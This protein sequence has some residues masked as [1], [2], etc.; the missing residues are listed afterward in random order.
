MLR[1][2]TLVGLIVITALVLGIYLVDALQVNVMALQL[3]QVGASYSPFRFEWIA[4]S[5]TVRTDR[6]VSER[7]TAIALASRMPEKG[8]SILVLANLYLL[9][10]EPWRTESLLESNDTEVARYLKAIACYWRSGSNCAIRDLDV[11]RALNR[12]GLNLWRVGET[13]EGF[14]RLLLAEQLDRSPTPD[15]AL[16]YAI[17]SAGANTIQHDSTAAIYWAQLRI[18]VQPSEPGGYLD[19]AALYLS[20]D[21]ADA[22]R[23]TLRMVEQMNV[24]DNWQFFSVMGRAKWAAGDR[25]G[26]LQDYLRAYKLNPAEITTAWYIGN[27]L[28]ALGRSEEACPYLK[29]VIDN[30]QSQDYYQYLAGV[31]RQLLKQTGACIQ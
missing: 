12:I 17:L 21:Q 19:L 15:K 18:Q 16:T 2:L 14:Y 29:T 7:L 5:A 8:Q 6:L 4:S 9:N 31:A 20:A 23:D 10:G 28:T 1:R 13:K 25:E 3:V 11:A 26:A 24:Q 27:A 30:D 22:A